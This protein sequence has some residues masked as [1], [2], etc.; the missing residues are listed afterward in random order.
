MML[1]CYWLNHAVRYT[2]TVNRSITALLYYLALIAPGQIL[3]YIFQLTL[4]V[5]C[6]NSTLQS[7]LFD[8]LRQT[9]TVHC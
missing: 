6:V 2:M 3:I 9:C 1:S 7:D 5:M 4:H 8:L